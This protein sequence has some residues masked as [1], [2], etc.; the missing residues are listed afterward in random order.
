M[1]TQMIF[2]WLVAWCSG[3]MLVFDRRTFPVLTSTCSWRV[4]IYFGKPF[5][6]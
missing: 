5:A 2:Q 3:R 4:T 1:V 6:V